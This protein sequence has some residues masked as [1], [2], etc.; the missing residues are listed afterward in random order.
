MSGQLTLLATHTH[1]HT[2]ILQLLKVK[3]LVC[4]C[5]LTVVYNIFTHGN[6]KAIYKCHRSSDQR[7]SQHHI[8][9]TLSFYVYF[10]TIK[11]IIKFVFKFQEFFF[12]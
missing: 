6:N 12:Y 9:K 4:F 7:N 10:V 11:R 2:H 1:T 8:R 3:N 5:D